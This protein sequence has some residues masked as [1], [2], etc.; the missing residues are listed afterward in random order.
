MRSVRPCTYRDRFNICVHVCSGVARKCWLLVPLYVLRTPFFVSR[1]LGGCVRSRVHHITTPS[2]CTQ[3]DNLVTSWPENTKFFTESPAI[4][5]EGGELM[6]SSGGYTVS[7][8]RVQPR[9]EIVRAVLCLILTLTHA[10]PNAQ[11]V[12]RLLSI[13]LPMSNALAPSLTTHTNTHTQTH[14][15][16]ECDAHRDSSSPYPSSD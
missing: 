5:L 7:G 11:C 6:Q 4:R 14:I 1:K 16:R 8:L 12:S 13:P 15:H 10:H 2:V 9:P 3:D